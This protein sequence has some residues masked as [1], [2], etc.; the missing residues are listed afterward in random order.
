[1]P[2]RRIRPLDGLRACA[3]L[4][5]VVYHLSELTGRTGPG[6]AGAVMSQFKSGVPV[7]FVISGFVLYLP[8]ARAIRDG[9]PRPRLGSYARRRALRILPAYWVALSLWL[10]VLVAATGLRPSF[11]WLSYYSLSQIYSLRTMS[12]GL[13]PAWSICVELSFYAL[14]PVFAWA[15]SRL[16]RPRDQLAVIAGGALASVALRIAVSG[17]AFGRVPIARAVLATS[18]PTMFDWFAAGL[19]LAVIAAEWQTDPAR[20]GRILRAAQ[21]PGL[22]WLAAGVLLGAAVPIQGGD[23]FPS[24]DSVAAHVMTGLAGGCLLLPLAAPAELMAHGSRVLRLLSS[25]AMVWLGTVSYGIFLFNVPVIAVARALTFHVGVAAYTATL[26]SL[27]ATITLGLLAIAGSI[28]CG[29]LSYYLVERPAQRMA[30]A[31]SSIPIYGRIRQ[32]SPPVSS[33]G[34]R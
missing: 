18:L 15:M 1:M 28:G 19:A 4:S 23:V 7:F 29:A 9:R 26:I 32:T 6:I 20:F 10:A 16:S 30:S 22:C 25:P 24:L 14:L 31:T 34:A 11:D 8:F 13:G 21:R 27:P 2:T 3:A 33:T 12:G 5:V 17:S